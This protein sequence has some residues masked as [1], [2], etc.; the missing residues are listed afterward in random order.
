MSKQTAIRAAIVGLLNSV[1]VGEFHPKERYA[2]NQ[3]D[4]VKLYGETINGG[5]IRLTSRKRSKLYEGRNKIT[6][7]YQITYLHFFSDD[8]DSQITFEDNL[9]AFDDAFMAT[10][11]IEPLT[12][13]SHWTDDGAGLAVDDAQPV[14]FAGVLCH[15]ALMTI[16][17]EYFE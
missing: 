11:I 10:D 9:E 3:R 12:D 17:L 14:M 13:A 1:K 2:K 4:M 15:R 16:T 8:N 6:L 7:R 5:F